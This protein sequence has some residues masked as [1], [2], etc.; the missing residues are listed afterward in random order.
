MIIRNFTGMLFLLCVFHFSY[1]GMVKI[2]GF[3]CFLNPISFKAGFFLKLYSFL[4]M[5]YLIG[6]EDEEKRAESF[7]KNLFI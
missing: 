7:L 6:L 1:I 3:Y 2:I 4:N 5:F